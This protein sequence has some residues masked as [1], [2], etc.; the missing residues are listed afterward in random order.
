L[1]IVASSLF[2]FAMPPE[3]SSVSGV[4]KDGGLITV[5][6]RNFDRNAT[7]S[8]QFFV[9]NGDVTVTCMDP[10][11]IA[12]V[13]QLEAFICSMPKSSSTQAAFDAVLDVVISVNSLSVRV[14]A[15]FSYITM[16]EVISVSTGARSDGGAVLTIV[17][18]GFGVT[19]SASMV[20]DIQLISQIGSETLSC[21]NVSYVSTASGGSTISCLLP[22]LA[23][24]PPS[25]YKVSLSVRGYRLNSTKQVMLIPALS[26]PLQGGT[27]VV[28]GFGIGNTSQLT[29]TV[30]DASRYAAFMLHP[31]STSLMQLT[32]TTIPDIFS[33]SLNAGDILLLLDIDSANSTASTRLCYVHSKVSSDTFQLSSMTHPFTPC[34]NAFSRSTAAIPLSSS[35]VIYLVQR[36]SSSSAV[37]VLTS[38]SALRFDV[39][40]PVV[41]I[42]TVFGS[43]DANTIYYIRSRIGLNSF[44]LS[45]SSFG[46]EIAVPNDFDSPVSGFMAIFSAYSTVITRISG[47]VLI[48]ASPSLISIGDRVQSSS[49]IVPQGIFYVKTKP[50]LRSFTLTKDADDSSPV[51]LSELG[52]VVISKFVEQTCVST[53]RLNGTAF[54]CSYFP[55]LNDRNFVAIADRFY[56]ARVIS[57][58]SSVTTSVRWTKV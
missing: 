4:T 48:S 32:M 28:R 46:D 5:I 19:D 6:G 35:D 44:T 2:N 13:N 51:L 40:D 49:G 47:D 16:P 3:I 36:H 42:G 31:V 43:F 15:M 1:P 23:S 10:V 30:S 45:L 11:T 12:N 20:K 18:T 29:V 54:T 8:V 37:A 33:K 24:A 52:A 41:F 22:Q 50:S 25:I 7:R 39:G 57:D 21:R 34:H 14:P 56:P 38:T 26:V 9:V 17:G 55:A 58:S 53:T 27:F